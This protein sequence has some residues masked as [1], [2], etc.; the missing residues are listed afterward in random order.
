M[1]NWSIYK[2]NT[3]TLTWD[4]DGTIPHPNADLDVDMVSTQQKISLADGSFAYVSPETKFDRTPLSMTWIYQDQTFKDKLEAYMTNSDYLKIV[5]H[6]GSGYY[7][8]IGKFIS[9]K[10]KW[11]V[12]VEPDAFDIDAVF[13]IEES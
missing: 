10:S 11:L 9:I 6:L 5:T 2:Y 1:S 4:A 8:F 13:E 7:T 3:G 12:G